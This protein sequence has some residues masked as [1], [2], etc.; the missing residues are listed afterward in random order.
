M[1]RGVDEVGLRRWIRDALTTEYERTGRG[2]KIEK[3][4][5]EPSERAVF[6]VYL[7]IILLALLTLLEALHIILLHTFNTDVFSLLTTVTGALL[8]FFFSYKA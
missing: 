8:G 1:E 6:A 7:A 3:V 5:R 4:V 2:K